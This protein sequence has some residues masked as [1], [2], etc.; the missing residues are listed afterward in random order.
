LRDLPNLLYTNGIEW[1]LYRDNELVGSPVRFSGDLTAGAR[2]TAPADFETLLTD[3]LRWRPAPITSVGALVRAV[4]PLTRLLRGEVQDQLASERR[5][6]KMGAEEEAQPFLGLARDWRAMLFP[7][8]DDGTFADG[9]A[10]AV[11]F[12][13]LLARTHDISLA[14]ASLHEIGQKLR[15]EHSLMGRALQLLTDEVAADFKVT[16]DLLVRVVDAVDWPRMRRGRRDT[17]L[18]L[19]EH[20]LELYDNQLRKES[21][22][23][24]TP[25][26]VVDEMVRLAEEVLVSRL[27]LARGFGDPD[28]FT[29]DP[30]MGT[31]TFLQTVLE[32]VARAAEARDG[33]GAV[34]GAVTQAVERMA[35]F[36]LQM[37]PYAVAELRVAEL[38]ALYGASP[39]PSGVK[40]YVTDTLDDP[41]AGQTQLSFALQLVAGARRRA[42]EIKAR[43][44]VTVVIGN[45]PY[46]ELAVGAGGWVE[47]G[48]AE[49][50]GG[51]AGAKPIL[52]DWYV[53]GAGRFKAKLKN[54]YVY[55]WRWATWKVWESPR[56]GRQ[57]RHRRG[58]LHLHRRLPD[59]SRLHRHARIP[60]APRF[61]RL[62]HQPDAR[63]A[64]P[65]HPDAGLPRGPA[66]PRHRPVRPQR[67]HPPGRAGIDPLPGADR[68]AGRQVRRAGADP[69]RRRWLA[70]QPHRLDRPA[71][72]GRR[73]RLGPVRS[74]LRPLPVVL[75]GR[76]PHPDLGLRP[77][78][79]DP[80]A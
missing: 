80:G 64:D 78:Q 56:Q 28:V 74:P 33:P 9:Y 32:R 46:A 34:A 38:L 40:L 14:G 77:E 60:P 5:A 6:V 62:D 47:N 1:R 79:G 18:H 55:F 25:R 12:A 67:G 15:A 29:V 61:R 13:L 19:Y 36:E 53:T 48:G 4:A 63:G 11:T 44:N 26:E 75:P 35:G 51:R 66:D 71:H 23:Y 21:G 45:P 76:I 59:G 49:L 50:A 43:A 8:A 31:G 27:G 7:Q 73:Q 57:R 52:A 70:G 54:L 17:Y 37:G 20:F 39:P 42:N 3:F 41:H 10:Q 2:L 72:P 68:P 16:L 22:S 69:D 58:L 24:Y 30:A 65:G